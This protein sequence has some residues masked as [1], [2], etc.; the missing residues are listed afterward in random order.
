MARPLVLPEIA[1]SGAKLPKNIVNAI[2]ALKFSLFF[3]TFAVE[4]GKI[5]GNRLRAQT[6]RDSCD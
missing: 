1:K 6:L 5:A 2:I 4:Y 3:C